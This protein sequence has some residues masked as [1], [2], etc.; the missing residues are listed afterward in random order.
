MGIS[1]IKNTNRTMV[2]KK[3]KELVFQPIL[4][5]YYHTSRMQQQYSLLVYCHHQ[6]WI[7]QYLLLCKC[8]CH[9]H[10]TLLNSYNN[11]TKLINKFETS[12]IINIDVV[13]IRNQRLKNMSGYQR[14]RA[15]EACIPSRDLAEACP[16]C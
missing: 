16:R 2:L 6:R 8:A 13:S 5:T 12:S 3:I 1:S 15:S 11:Y 9:F 4:G 10:K 7:Q 14:R